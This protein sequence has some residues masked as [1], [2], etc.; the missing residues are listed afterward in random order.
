MSNVQ[1]R[2][3]KK[4]KKGGTLPKCC[5]IKREEVGFHVPKASEGLSSAEECGCNHHAHLRR[6][7]L[8]HSLHLFSFILCLFL[9]L[10][11][12]CPSSN[13]RPL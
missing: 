10:L 6:D 13:A 12:V 9:Q 4:K 3:K 8:D 7:A 11:E 1:G 2:K 5:T